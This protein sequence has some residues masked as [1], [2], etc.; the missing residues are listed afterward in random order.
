MAIP[1]TSGMVGSL[2]DGAENG[3]G[4][5]GEKYKEVEESRKQVQK[6]L[7]MGGT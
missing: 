1:R 6:E 7:E 3:G 4:Y 5:P 2:R